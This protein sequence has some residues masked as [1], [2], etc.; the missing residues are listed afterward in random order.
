MAIA[1]I[2][3]LLS[4]LSAVGLKFLHW[5]RAFVQ[6]FQNKKGR[7][8]LSCSRSFKAKVCAAQ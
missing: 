5:L 8:P 4:P 7:H 2:T 3:P 1:A 6:E